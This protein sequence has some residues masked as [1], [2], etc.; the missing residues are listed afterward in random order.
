MW[1][2]LSVGNMSDTSPALLRLQRLAPFAAA[3]S[4]VT[5]AAVHVPRTETFEGIDHIAAG[6]LVT[7]MGG[8]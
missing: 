6:T 5:L 4:S 7:R 2:H 1:D 3:R 8:Y